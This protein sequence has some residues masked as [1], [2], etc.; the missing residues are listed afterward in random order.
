MLSSQIRKCLIVDLFSYFLMIIVQEI[1]MLCNN[2]L[3]ILI[4]TGKLSVLI[5]IVTNIF[6]YKNNLFNFANI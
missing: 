2:I 6:L 5:K 1:M 3:N 4:F